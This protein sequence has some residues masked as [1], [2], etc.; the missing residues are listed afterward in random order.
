MQTANATA[1]RRTANAMARPSPAPSRGGLLQ[2]KCACGTHTR[3][4]GE[5]SECSKRKRLN[6]QREV[7]QG[8]RIEVP[9]SYPASSQ[10][11]QDGMRLP[12]DVRTS[13]A[14]LYGDE[15][16][17][18]RV[19]HDAA[20]DA[21]AREVNARAFTLG[22]HIHFAAGQWRPQEREGVR[23]I[24]HEL[25]HTLQQRGAHDTGA[26][27]VDI[28]P[29]DSPLEREA[30]VAADAAL[31]GRAASVR[32]GSAAGT[33]AKLL[34]RDAVKGTTGIGSA[35]GGSESESK[36]R[37]ID[38]NTTVHIERTVTERPCTSE[39]STQKTPSDKIFYWDKDAN[40]VGLHYSIC[41]GRVQLSSKGEISY[42]KVIESAKGLLTT[43]QNNP[44]L[45]S[46]PGA[47]LDN[48]LDQ[49]TVSGSGDITLTVDGILQASIQGNS[50]V[51]TGGQKLNV[52]GVLKITPQGMSFTVTGGADF[53]KTP[54]QSTTTY[55]LEGKVATEHFAV[56]LRYEQIDTSKVNGPSS[57]KGQVVGGLDI[58][59]PD[60]GPLKNT[61]FGPT[62][63]VPTD[64]G[65]PVFGGGFKGTFG[66]PDKT[67]A[68]RCFQCD[69]PPPLPKY[70]CTRNVKA[71]DRPIEK[72]PAK[73]LT[74]KLLYNYNSTAP[75]NK[76]AFS[77]SVASIAGMLGEGFSV[78]HI[79]GY[80]SPEGS[81]DAPNP[82]VPGF[83][84]NIELSWR[85]ADY[86]RTQIAA[87]AAKKTPDA[88]LPEAVGKGEQLG[89]I[90]G[91]GETADK[92][93]TPQLVGLLAPLSDEQR[94]D[95]LGVDD[96]VRGDPER[97]RKALADIQAFVDGRDARGL[98]LANRPRWEKVFPFLRRV[99][100]GLHKD[101]VM[102]KEPVAASSKAGCDESDISYAMAN[103]SPLPPQRRVP[104]EECGKR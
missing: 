69:C 45:G 34:Q 72:E 51:G 94:L 3:G 11:T 17:G 73:N 28:G 9:P 8:G 37:D 58:P 52:R 60:I 14:P 35:A 79:W 74:T 50:T 67:P 16:A 101:K 23:L 24:A 56:S 96:A 68:V 77:G 85:R 55:T 104:Q 4:G 59:L 82:P 31:A 97:R 92:D 6:L 75:A 62:V 71:H 44:A 19:H 40:A 78:E 66:G 86:A 7:D 102:G 84:G 21:A 5:C 57:S 26:G 10:L 89:D 29:A 12:T 22:Q 41:N 91:S 70:S 43:L 61:T 54:L 39:A 81:L 30:D 53:S 25:G 2:R 64:G 33:Q 42:D 36:E 76:D 88:V 18:V 27:P 38:E 100:V 48:R 63:T 87:L 49:A 98:G 99:E 32:H 47:L 65:P 93:L 90:G 83:K 15:F 103:M 20:S 13:L 1:T 80:A 95:T 46:N